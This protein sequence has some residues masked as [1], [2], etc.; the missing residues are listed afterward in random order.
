MTSPKLTER[1]RRA[2]RSDTRAALAYLAPGMSGFVLFIV[3]PLVASLVM[4]LFNWPL[5]GDPTFVGAGNYVDLFTKDPLFYQVLGNTVLFAVAYT[6]TN[7]VICV[8]IAR[9]L[10]STGRFGT[11]VRVLMFIPV[12][13]PMVANAMIWKLMLADDG[14]INSILDVFGI[15]AVPWLSTGNTAMFSLVL[16]SLW[17]GVGYNIVVLTAGLNAI[18]PTLYEAAQIDGAGPFARFF[19]ITLPLLTPSIFFCTVMTVI[20]AFKVFAQPYML[21]DGGPGASTTTLVL[22]LYQNGFSWD[23]L[24]YASALAWVLFVIVMLITALQFSQQKRVNYD[25]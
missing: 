2:A 4:S 19:R 16:M 3:L 18:N 9:W 17:Q 13:T 24:G 8:L 5:F 20:G 21:T 15:P 25:A 23:K 12:V 22:Y 1:T 6:I 14:L 7:L 11:V 10:L